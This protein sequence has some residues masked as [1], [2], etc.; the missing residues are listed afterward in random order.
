M[1]SK[2]VPKFEKILTQS[3]LVKVR[4]VVSCGNLLDSLIKSKSHLRDSVFKD[5]KTSYLKTN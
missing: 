2:Q 4:E 1:R 5:A 3:V